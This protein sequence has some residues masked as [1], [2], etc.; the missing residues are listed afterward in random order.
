M[1]FQRITDDKYVTDFFIKYKM[2]KFLLVYA[3]YYPNLP[4]YINE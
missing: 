4:A 1:E 3:T 2:S